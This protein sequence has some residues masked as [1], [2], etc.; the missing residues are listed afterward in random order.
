MSN[1]GA[2][3]Y[4]PSD[5]ISKVFIASAVITFVL[6]LI[7]QVGFSYMS[8]VDAYV[9]GG[10]DAIDAGDDGFIT[11]LVMI[12]AMLASAI[13]MAVGFLVSVVMFC[14]WVFRANKNAQA[15]KVKGMDYSAGWCVGWFFIP[16]ANLWKPYQAVQEI[17]RASDPFVYV[18]GGEMG[19][20]NSS[21]VSWWWAFWILFAVLDRLENRIYMRADVSLQTEWLLCLVS[22]GIHLFL[23]LPAT[24]LVIKVV[25]EI[26]QRQA[27]R[28]AR[29]K[30][31]LR[32]SEAYDVGSMPSYPHV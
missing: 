4:R 32:E 9:D 1:S 29:L 21:L 24:V 13:G 14:M 2:L 27:E 28:Y 8:Y 10:M 11:L 17:W 26:N 31:V 7:F 6:G 3:T 20:F 19:K 25:R 15:M 23:F 16:I 18:K 30:K 12:L 5:V 22:L